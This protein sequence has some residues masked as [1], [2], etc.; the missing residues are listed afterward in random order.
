MAYTSQ[1]TIIITL[2]FMIAISPSLGRREKSKV[3]K[4]LKEFCAQTGKSKEC[5]KIIKPKLREFHDTD[6]KTVADVIL[7]LARAKGDE[8]HEELNQL[9]KDSRDDGLKEKYLSCFKNYNDAI[10]NLNLAWRNLESD[11]YQNIPVQIDDTIEEMK[12]CRFEFNKDSFDPSHIR[13]REKEFRV[14]VDI[15]KVATFR[16][17]NQLD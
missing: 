11:N 12:G 1:R 5:W 14:Y 7:D 8:I 6:P 15:A 13:N 2:I 17:L 9:Y 4:D 16:L 3:K 10:R